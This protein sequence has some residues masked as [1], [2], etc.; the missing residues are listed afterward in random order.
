[1]ASDPVVQSASDQI[2]LVLTDTCI[3]GDAI[4]FDGTNWVRADADA[5]AP[6]RAEYFAVQRCFTSGD[7][8]KVARRVVLYDADAPY[9]L[10][11]LQFLSGTAGKHTQT[12][13]AAMG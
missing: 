9:T 7:T 11:A 4:G 5:T 1:M 13:P 8:I 3:A 10:G 12:N 2:D 6:I